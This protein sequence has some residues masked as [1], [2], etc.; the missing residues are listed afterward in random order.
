VVNLQTTYYDPSN[1]L[2]QDRYSLPFVCCNEQFPAL[3]GDTLKVATMKPGLLMGNLV[4]FLNYVLLGNSVWSIGPNFR[5]RCTKQWTKF[6]E[7]P[8]LSI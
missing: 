7:P 1:V 5:K 3:K 8:L 6:N 4:H 2:H